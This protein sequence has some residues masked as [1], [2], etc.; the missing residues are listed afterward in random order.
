MR[1]EGLATALVLGVFWGA[2]CS[3][4]Q[5]VGWIDTPL[6]WTINL[7]GGLLIGWNGN[8]IYDTLFGWVKR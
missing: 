7:V 8:E 2:A 1:F 5:H 6:M 4:A 3:Y